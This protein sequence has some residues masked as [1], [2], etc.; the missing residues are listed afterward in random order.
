MKNKAPLTIIELSLMLLVFA[1]AA[2]FCLR[3]FLWADRESKNIVARDHAVLQAQ[4]AVELLK[5]CDGDL[6]LL[7]STVGGTVENTSWTLC[8]DEN[9]KA[10]ESDHIYALQVTLHPGSSELL[11]TASVEVYQG[12]LCLT[13]LPAA[14]QK[15]VPHA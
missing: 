11:G 3:A 1:L 6:N 5:S 7:V 10:T 9:W 4:N 2:A 14:W 15:E 8:F 12:D 13:S